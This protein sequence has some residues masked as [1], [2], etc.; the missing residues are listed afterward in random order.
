MDLRKLRYLET[1][2]RLKS[3]TKAAEALYISQPSLSNA[4]LSLE[5]ELGVTL[6]N[7]SRPPLRF[8]QDGER[9]M[10]HVY[11]ILG[12]VRDAEDEMKEMARKRK[13]TLMLTWPSITVNDHL[14]SS[15]Y[16]RFCRLFPEYS[17]IIQDD[18]IKGTITRLM[19]EELDLAM[20][21]LPE[22]QDMTHFTYIPVTDSKVCVILPENHELA[23]EDEISYEMLKDQTILTFQPGSLIRSE[24]EMNFSRMGITPSIISVNQMDFAKKLV[25]QKQGIS[26]GTMDLGL[27]EMK[28]PG[29][30]M[31]PLQDPLI[32]HKGFLL[33]RG[34][35][36]NR[37]VT[38]LI[39]FVIGT[40]EKLRMS[41]GDGSH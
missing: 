9:F 19:S 33:K 15:I 1:I 29:L 23:W 35:P 38:N 11:R 3:F 8:T 36:N 4:I 40:T 27:P 7:R 14:L 41:H 24:I 30:V 28:E 5:K 26:F 13:Q 2:Y 20:V 25:L 37:A 21:H 12:D 31:L 16:T 10:W 32:L 34:R 18:T 22:S 17:V 6:I 39:E